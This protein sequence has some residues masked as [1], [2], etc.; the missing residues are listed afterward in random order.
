MMITAIKFQ[1][2]KC[3][4]LM[5][6]GITLLLIVLLTNG[7]VYANRHQTNKNKVTNFFNEEIEDRQGLEQFLE[8]SRKEATQ[9]IES[10]GAIEALGAKE[11]ELENKTSE[12]NSISANSLE[13]RGQEERAKEENAYY[14]QLEVD[15]TDPQII[16]HKKD[17]DK[18]AD[19][20]EKLMS[21]LLEGLKEF[22]IDCKTVKGDEE[23]EPEYVLEIEKEHF[24]DTTYNKTLCEELRNKYNCTD[25]LKVKC[26][27]TGPRY[28][29]WQYKTIRFG[30]AE[31]HN[32]KM[33]WGYA[34]KRCRKEWD[35]LITPNHPKRGPFG[36]GDSLQVDSC[37]RDNP[38]AIVAD[39]RVFIA[40]KVGAGLDQIR[41]D[42]VFPPEGRGI[43]NQ[44]WGVGRW[45][46]PWEEY[47]FGY[48]YRDIYQVCE[49]W[50]E[51]WTE[52]CKLQ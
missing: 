37:W 34:R 11:H 23:I 8:D 39:A 36:Y 9:G 15:Y 24:K 38:A 19:A 30:G 50:D 1:A 40:G 33:D 25:E 12:L 46:H 41:E 6:L 3:L 29:E 52:E 32:S 43:G 5:R 16:H 10:K 14:D 7:S 22:D 13:S 45:R 21:R 31:L 4:V 18:I 44:F 2:K 49:L 28:G 42:I 26:T 48:W 20:N 51:E 35:W 17:I 27:R 47:E